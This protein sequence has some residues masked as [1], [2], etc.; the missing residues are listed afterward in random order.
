[1]LTNATSAKTNNY[2]GNLWFFVSVFCKIE[3]VRCM[4]RR[5]GREREKRERERESLHVYVRNLCNH[6]QVILQKIAGRPG[7]RGHPSEGI[8]PF[9][10]L[11]GPRF[12]AVM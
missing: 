4:K 10:R 1:M 12:G 8:V 2:G 11:S 9:K 3:Q 5:R 6:G 7:V